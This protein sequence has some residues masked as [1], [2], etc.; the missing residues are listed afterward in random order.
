MKMRPE[1]FKYLCE[2]LD[3]APRVEP[4]VYAKQGLSLK[5][6]RWDSMYRA[7]LSKWVCDELYS[8]LNDTHIDTALREYYSH[9]Y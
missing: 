6:Y 3:K 2:A 5:R 7:K 8:Y 4:D 9:P 1:H